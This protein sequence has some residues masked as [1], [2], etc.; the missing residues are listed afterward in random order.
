MFKRDVELKL[1]LPDE[2][3]ELGGYMPGRLDVSTGYKI[4]TYQWTPPEGI[5]NAKGVA[6]LLH[7]VFSHISF[8]W[9][10]ADEENHRILLKGSVIERLLNEGLVVIGHDHPGH[11]RSTGLHGFVKTHDYLR[12]TAIEVIEHFTNDSTP[13]AGLKKFLMGMSMGG[14]TAIRVCEKA[15]ELIDAYVLLSPAVKPPDDMFGA[16][17]RILKFIS[18]VLNLSVPYLPVLSLPPSPHARIRDAV[19]RDGLVHR[20]SLRVRMGTEFLR[21]YSEVNERAHLLSFGS[22]VVL[23]GALDQ[24]VSPTGIQEFVSRIN[25][26]DKQTLVFPSLGH[27]VMH[28]DPGCEEAIDKLIQWVSERL[29]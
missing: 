7:G 12:D 20:G 11:G 23:V 13:L 21:V 2:P 15:P 27:E 19:E 9:L 16:K 18:P 10:A 8:D 26:K 3:D 6:F 14:T 25:S 1:T 22:V 24:I 4:A 5:A 29:Q 28:E 17:G